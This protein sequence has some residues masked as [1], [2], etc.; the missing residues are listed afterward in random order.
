MSSRFVVV[1]LQSKN[2]LVLFEMSLRRCKERPKITKITTFQIVF[3]SARLNSN[4]QTLYT[5]YFHTGKRHCSCTHTVIWMPPNQTYW[6]LITVR[7]AKSHTATQH[8][9]HIS[10]SLLTKWQ[11]H[12]PS[13]S[14]T[15]CLIFCADKRHIQSVCECM[16]V[17]PAHMGQ[18]PRSINH[19]KKEQRSDIDIPHGTKT[20]THMD[21]LTSILTRP[22]TPMD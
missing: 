2:S 3:P 11:K 12:S 1:A 15:F 20:H 19:T 21:V 6:R 10:T 14:C 7:R 18:C 22:W 4:S 5:H 17:K 13:M 9:T 8:N 16:W